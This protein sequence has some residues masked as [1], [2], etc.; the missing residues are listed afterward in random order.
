MNLQKIFFLLS[1]IS[2]LILL[3]IAQA[4]QQP[5][6]QGKLKSIKYGNNKISLKIENIPEEIIL[7]E[8]KIIPIRPNDYLTIHG[9]K[10]TFMNKTQ[11]IADK[12]IK[13]SPPQ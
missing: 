12:I 2:I 6:A 5:L 7:F 8:N 10:D 13:N 9:R 3:F 11:I 4:P 1:I